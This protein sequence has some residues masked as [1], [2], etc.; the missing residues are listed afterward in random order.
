MGRCT[1]GVARASGPPPRAYPS[2]RRLFYPC[3][4]PTHYIV[5]FHAPPCPCPAPS[6]H[7]APFWACT[8]HHLVPLPTARSPTTRLQRPA[9]H[10]A[11]IESAGSE[12]GPRLARAA[13]VARIL[14]V[15]LAAVVALAPY[16]AYALSTYR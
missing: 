15:E 16:G 5:I 9:T 4:L 1:R 13:R 10:Q 8:P 12:L 6:L 14:G 2:L 11:D 3:K 7:P